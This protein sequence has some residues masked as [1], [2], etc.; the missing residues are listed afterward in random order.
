M[1]ISRKLCVHILAKPIENS[2]PEA[3]QCGILR[4]AIEHQRQV[5]DNQV[6][7][8]VNRVGDGVVAIKTG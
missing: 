8:A 5:Q 2:L 4:Q 7:A 6:E 1:P 3:L